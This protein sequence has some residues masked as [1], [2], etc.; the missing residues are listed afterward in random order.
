MTHDSD[1]AIIRENID[2]EKQ[3][4]FNKIQNA[5]DIA[6]LEHIRVEYLS[7]QIEPEGVTRLENVTKGKIRYF[8]SRLPSIH[9]TIR[10]Q[11]GNLFNQFKDEVTDKIEA[12]AQELKKTS[13]RQVEFFDTTLPGK[14][15][16]LG[17]RHPVYQTLEEMEYIFGKLGFDIIMGPEIESE[18]NNFELLNIPLEHA[19]RDAFETFYIEGNILL[20]SH[21]SPAQIRAMKVMKPPLRIIVPGKVFRPDT[22]DAGHSPIF[23]QVEG[24]MVGE[25]VTFA[26]LKGVL[27]LFARE[28]FGEKTRMRFRPSFFPFTEPSA[29]VDISCTICGGKGCSACKMSGWL[30]ILG[31]GMVHPKVFEN[32]GY[33]PEKYTGFAFGMGVER[34]AML[35]YGINDIRLFTENHKEFLKQF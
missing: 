14:K 11:C 13:K 1:L 16:Y 34:I 27:E 10:S 2:R 30:E 26:H 9:E 23:H 24:L 20:R 29:E 12:K 7:R 17:Y 19:S 5:R 15:V 28:M 4:A 25:D 33:D 32:V 18:H 35:K 21:T 6:D 8:F 3:R 31:S 22:P